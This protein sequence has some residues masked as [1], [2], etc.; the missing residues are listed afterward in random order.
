MVVYQLP[1]YQ[2]HENPYNALLCDSLQEAGAQIVEY[3]HAGLLKGPKP[4][5]LHIHW[6]EYWLSRKPWKAA[7][8]HYQLTMLS[9]LLSRIRG[10]KVVW[11]AHNLRPHDSL[12]PDAE[13]RFY[14]MWAKK[15]DGY[16]CLSQSA[17]KLLGET[18][19]QF[20]PVPHAVIPHGHYRSRIS[21]ASQEE[22][23][24][25]LRV[26]PNATVLGSFGAIR[27][28]KNIPHLIRQFRE[29]AKGNEILLIAGKCGED[30]LQ[31]EIQAAKGDDERVRLD[32]RFLPD[33]L[34][35]LYVSASDLLAFPYTG[36]L[37]SGSALY[38]LSVGRPLIAPAQ[39]SL[40][41]L[42]D[43]VGQDWMHLYQGQF[44]SE[45][46]RS[47]MDQAHE[48]ASSG[49]PD[50]SRY[51]WSRIGKDTMEFYRKIGA[52]L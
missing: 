51:E 40:P 2:N 31:R 50:L 48:L 37:N 28:Y 6:P 38:A 46:L 26:D 4:S 14:Q 45:V 10:A 35:E 49:Q 43:D 41:E 17:L 24:R 34:I 47:A 16:T 44:T 42:R 8:R 21:G 3:S 11:T 39:G 1:G 18:H 25:S 27:P 23:R 19:P 30:S 13:K 7:K 52:T 15:I 22:A 32:F 9:L 36:I 5:I 12:Y 29:S 33:D 20:G